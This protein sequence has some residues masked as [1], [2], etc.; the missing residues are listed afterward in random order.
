[1]NAADGLEL[2]DSWLKVHGTAGERLRAAV[3]EVR[4]G[5]NS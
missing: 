1:M 5:V 2:I 3:M 4:N